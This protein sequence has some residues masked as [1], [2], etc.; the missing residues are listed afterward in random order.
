MTTCPKC[1]LPLEQ[2]LFRPEGTLVCPSGH[3]V[4][5]ELA[6]LKLDVTDVP[7]DLEAFRAML[8]R[9]QVR[10]MS[11]TDMDRPDRTTVTIENLVVDEQTRID[12][13][14]RFTVRDGVLVEVRARRG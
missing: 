5:P 14:F 2:D 9:A 13:E 6:E 7:H 10:S 12:V 1:G 11:I 4:T 8:D 3:V